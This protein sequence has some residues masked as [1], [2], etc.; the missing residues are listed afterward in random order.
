[1]GKRA[2]VRED[3]VVSSPGDGIS[4]STQVVNWLTLPW[5]HDLRRPY[6][7]GTLVVLV[8]VSS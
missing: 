4:L 7:G 5:T 1:M 6:G 3:V 8:V 2:E